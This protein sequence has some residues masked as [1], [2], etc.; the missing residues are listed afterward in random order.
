MPSRPRPTGR[1][2]SELG[3]LGEQIIG[4]VIAETQPHRI[5]L[6]QHQRGDRTVVAAVLM[7]R[8]LG[9]DPVCEILSGQNWPVSTG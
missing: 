3:D 1:A 6:G 7:S 2:S 5:E 9:R 8:P 4:G